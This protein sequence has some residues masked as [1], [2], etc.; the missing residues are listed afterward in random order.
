MICVGRLHRDIVD[1][2][3]RFGSG[4]N[5][6]PIFENTFLAPQ[7]VETLL[8]WCSSGEIATDVILRKYGCAHQGL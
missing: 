2:L 6:G 1:R 4:N 7:D 3:K 5:L 8:R